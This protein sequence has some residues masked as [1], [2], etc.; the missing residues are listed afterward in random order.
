MSSSTKVVK[1]ARK[2]GQ[3]VQGCDV[4]IGRACYMGGWQLAKS[5]WANPYSVKECGNAEKAV[6]KFE[7]YFLS[8]EE[9]VKDV[10][11]LKGKTLGWFRNA[12]FIKCVAFN[13]LV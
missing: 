4:Y 12:K 5:K 6:E 13:K 1:I 2:N 11:E 9:L 10:G 3:V 8:N 7:E